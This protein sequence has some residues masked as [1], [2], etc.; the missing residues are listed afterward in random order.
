MQDPRQFI[1]YVLPGLTFVIEV[2]LYLY[3]TDPVRAKCLFWGIVSYQSGIAG[4]LTAFLLSGG[5]GYLFSI[6]YYYF[7]GIE[8]NEFIAIRLGDHRPMLRSAT[9]LGYLV[10][11]REDNYDVLGRDE[12]NQSITRSG[13]WRIVNTLW[14]ERLETCLRIKGANAG[15]DT[16]AHIAHGLGISLFGSIIAIFVGYMLQNKIELHTLSF[17]IS[18]GKFVILVI[19]ISFIVYCHYVTYRRAIDAAYGVANKTLLGALRYES[20][21]N[22][23]PVVALV[24][25]QDINDRVANF[26][27]TET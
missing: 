26:P 13:A 6:V 14:H 23:E 11:H 20:T 25:N 24:N 16:R 9:G 22:G 5:I 27:D 18:F 2:A 4:L 21:N 15:N 17:D 1:R 12:V 8:W 10:F 7:Y 19:I 3:L